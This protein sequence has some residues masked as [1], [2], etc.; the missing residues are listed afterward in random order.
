MV[1]TKE[2][3]RT[4]GKTNQR[5]SIRWLIN[6][7]GHTIG[8]SAERITI[9]GSHGKYLIVWD[10]VIVCRKLSMYI[11]KTAHQH[12]HQYKWIVEHRERTRDNCWDMLVQQRTV[13]ISG[14]AL[15]WK[16]VWANY[17]GTSNIRGPKI[18]GAV[19]ATREEWVVHRNFIMELQRTLQQ[20]KLDA[21]PWYYWIVD[22]TIGYVHKCWTVQTLSDNFGMDMVYDNAATE[23]ECDQH[24]KV[25]PTYVKCND[26]KE[27]ELKHHRYICWEDADSDWKR[28]LMDSMWKS[29]S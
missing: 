25:S 5:P 17:P 29:L 19:A 15:K 1:S 12:R 7:Y 24:K 20:H 4:Y 11:S 6:F 28:R 16:K 9:T 10:I 14:N 27:K 21:M 13:T 26:S 8:I 22:G 18:R 3:Q 23:L 2:E